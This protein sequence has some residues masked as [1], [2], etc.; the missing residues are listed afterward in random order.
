[1]LCGR[2]EGVRADPGLFARLSAERLTESM[3]LTVLMFHSEA[4]EVH[5][6][7]GGAVGGGLRPSAA[8][9]GFGVGDAPLGVRRLLRMP[10]SAA[11]AAMYSCG[12]TPE[13]PGTKRPAM[14]TL[15]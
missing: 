10:S 11:A 14:R 1:V 3:G 6:E 9:L 2:G 12:V 15:E 4:T 13:V 5:G 7:I 8:E